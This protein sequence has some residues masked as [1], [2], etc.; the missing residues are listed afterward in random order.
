MNTWLGSIG[1]FVLGLALTA[2]AQHSTRE[3]GVSDDGL[4]SPIQT[5]THRGD[6]DLLSAG[7]G[8][9]GLRG[10]GSAFADPEHP[11]AAELRRRA[12]F[13]N[14]R[15]IA[16]L[17]P[18][19]GYGSIYGAVPK[20]EGREFAAFARVPGVQSPHRVLAQVPDAF[21]AKRRCLVVSASSGSR[22]VYGAIAVAG[23]W[24]LP[25]GC[26]VAY[27][28]KGAGTGYFDVAS[29]T[30][31]A[32]DGTRALRG[33]MPLEFEPA[34]GAVPFA[35]NEVLIKHAH[36][37]DNPEADW[38]RHVLQAA[39]FGLR[40]L[41]EAFPEQAPFTPDNTRVIA[42]GLSNGGGA[43]LR[44]AE[45]DAGLL[46]AVVAI[47]PNVL[48]AEGG[49]ALYD[50]TSEA[51]MFLPCALLDARFDSVPF[52]RHAGQP[53]GAWLA[54]CA[55]L[56]SGGWLSTD[57]VREQAAEA[58]QILRASGWTDAGLESAA[59]ST[60]LDLWRAVAVTYAAAYARTG[61]GPMP[62]GF[63]FA[64]MGADGA[65]H[66]AG[67]AERAAWWAD[68]TGIAPG[69]GIGIL[70]SSAQGEDPTWPGTLCLRRLWT[71]GGELGERLHDGVD[72]T[73]AGLPRA[74]LPILIVHGKADGL[75]PIGFSSQAYVD[76]LRAQD[77]QPM[78]WQVGHGQHFDAFLGFP[79]F[80]D[81]HVPMLPYAYAALDRIDAYL[82]GTGAR[83]ESQD[84]ATTPRGAAA[85][86]RDALGTF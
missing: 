26:A 80:G 19:G 51:A 75:L 45:A 3:V 64:A 14:W 60:A 78:F 27:T 61:V 86:D 4:I 35:A 23:A 67:M 72:A 66:A 43:V 83:P 76:W 6:D 71:E 13:T 42:V 32:L 68:A 10:T 73:R 22:G 1:T 9:D 63:G 37:G 21:D 49:R 81:R 25:R 12:I 33:S 85:L 53:P 28:D 56:R 55:S 77:R 11:T 74:D 38:G 30:G 41:D 54:R 20:V 34:A 79:G 39:H 2:C 58:L 82:D 69:A 7:L 5:S 15:G 8:L 50:Y 62:C 84:I 36:S 40:A 29:G 65:T 18:L 48:A 31:V 24:G 47:E 59:A 52:A 16:D 44:A 57:S 70:D 17:G 46:D